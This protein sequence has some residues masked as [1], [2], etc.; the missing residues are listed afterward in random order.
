M[1]A[2][3]G[4]SVVYADTVA[5][6]GYGQDPQ[7]RFIHVR[8]L[9]RMHCTC[10]ELIY[11][12][13]RLVDMYTFL[14]YIAPPFQRKIRIFPGDTG[15]TCGRCVSVVKNTERFNIRPG[16]RLKSPES[17]AGNE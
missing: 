5:D 7:L 12:K 17:E 4:A 13:C 8:Q 10:F 16:S 6:Y 3:G 9:F 11:C 2:G 15:P 14:S 1:V